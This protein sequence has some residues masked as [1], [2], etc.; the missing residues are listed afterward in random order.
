METKLIRHLHP[1]KRDNGD[2]CILATCIPPVG[3]KYEVW[4]ALWCKRKAKDRVEVCCIPFFVY[5]LSLGDIILVDQNQH[6]K[7]VI[8]ESGH[9]TFRVWF[10]DS[11]DE[12]IREDVIKG[13]TEKGC[14]F[15]WS[16][17]NLLAI[18]TP[19]LRHAQDIAHFL[20]EKMDQGSLIYETGK[21]NK[22]R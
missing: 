5:N 1:V 9:Y 4:E 16:T 21:V 8:K 13:V 3:T 14:G 20:K 19:T 17:N 18:D 10:G 7:K 11:K 15:E 12:N 2:A 22:Y 6:M